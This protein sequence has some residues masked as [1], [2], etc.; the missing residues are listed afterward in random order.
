[1]RPK[2]WLS[3]CLLA[4]SL[5]SQSLE[6]A[7]LMQPPTD[8]WPMF[9]GD[10][11]GRR[12][13]TLKK[14][15]DSNISSLSFA[16]VY[17]ASVGNGGFGGSIKATPLVIQGVMYFTMPDH[18]WAIDAR[19]GREIWRYTWPSKGGIHIGSRGAAAY[20]NTLYFE[21]PDCNLVAL[22]MKDGTKKWSAPICDLDQM[23]FGSSAPLIVKNH[24]ITGVSGDDLDVPGYIESHDPETGAR[25][26]R[27]Y[28]HPQPGDPGSEDLA[29]CRSDASRRRHDMGLDHLRSGTQPHLLR[30]GQ[31][32]ARHCG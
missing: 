9:N 13:C 23:Y 22:N 14:I 29:E 24:V 1:M 20:G 18:A 3:A 12:F 7:K 5:A 32:A 16:W 17:R 2:I 26:W 19:T 25:Q 21:T 8:T 27:W 15:N 11:S 28:A 4:A 30:Y 6:P 31:P 10:Y